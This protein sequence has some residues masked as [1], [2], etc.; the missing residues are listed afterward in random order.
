AGR[1]VQRFRYDNTPDGLQLSVLF[2]GGTL[3]RALGELE[4][5]IWQSDKPPVLVW[6]AVDGGGERMLVGAH[7]RPAL[8]E[9]IMQAARDLGLNLL[10]PLLDLEDMAKVRFSDVWGGFAE[11]IRAGSE[12]Y[13]TPVVVMA[14]VHREGNDWVGRW[15]LLDPRIGGVW[16]TRG[17]ALQD[18]LAMGPQQLANRLHPV[19]AR[20]PNTQASTDELIVEVQGV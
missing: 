15:T 16:Q 17:S 8:R 7:E 14:R 5:P 20:V 13:G 4:V 2:E 18:A 1:F 12:R 10:F 11:T 6:L 19:Y 9:P 3:H